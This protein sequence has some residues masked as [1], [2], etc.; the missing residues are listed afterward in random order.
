[1]PFARI[2]LDHTFVSATMGLLVTE[3]FAKVIYF[4]AEI[5]ARN[6]K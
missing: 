4:L 3:N 2:P 5:Q 6:S 1:M